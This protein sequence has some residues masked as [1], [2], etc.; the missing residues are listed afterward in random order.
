MKKFIMAALAAFLIV[1]GVSAPVIACAE[2]LPPDVT[3]QEPA[4]TPEAP[5]ESIPEETP[6][7]ETDGPAEGA[8]EPAVPDEDTFMENLVTDFIVELKSRYGEQW[9]SY[10]NAILSEWGTVEQYL[11][12]LIPEDAPDPVKNGWEG[13]VAWLGEYS[14]VWG[15]TLAVIGVIVVGVFGKKFLNRLLSF[16]AKIGARFCQVFTASNKQAKAIKAQNDAL[17]ALLGENPKYADKRA[18]L[19][20][21]GEELMKD[22][23]A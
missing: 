13:F 8:D 19:E 5:E 14:P 2:E 10:Y 17:L 11:L 4:E 1:T 6:E 21:T 9:E 18:A 22:D 7:E 15:T 16:V 12:S 3:A 20:Q 23:D